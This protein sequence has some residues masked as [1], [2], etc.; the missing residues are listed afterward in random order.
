MKKQWREFLKENEICWFYGVVPALVAHLDDALEVGDE[1]I[2]NDV[3]DLLA[4]L[5]V[6]LDKNDNLC[7]A[8]DLVNKNMLKGGKNET[9]KEL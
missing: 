9:Q 5:G 2:I 3:I 1:A 4:Y 8:V 6:V 7:F